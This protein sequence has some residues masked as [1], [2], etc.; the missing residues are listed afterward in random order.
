MTRH[1]I[2][3][4]KFNA[5]ERGS[6]IIEQSQINSLFTG[7]FI[8]MFVQAKRLLEDLMCFDINLFILLTSLCGTGKTIPICKE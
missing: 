6:F 1:N 3:R 2:T 4:L 5:S 8:M 7:Q